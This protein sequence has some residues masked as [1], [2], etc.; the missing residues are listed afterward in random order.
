MIAA[1]SLHRRLIAGCAIVATLLYLTI[2][3]MR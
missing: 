2:V 3:M 1:F